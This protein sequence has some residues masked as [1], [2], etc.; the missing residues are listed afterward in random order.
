MAREVPFSA[1][2]IDAMLNVVVAFAV[3]GVGAAIITAPVW[4]PIYC[5]YSLFKTDKKK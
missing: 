1:V 2:G 5:I 4:V 3:V